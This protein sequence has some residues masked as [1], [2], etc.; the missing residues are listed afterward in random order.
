[1]G[2]QVPKRLYFGREVSM[3][4]NRRVLFDYALPKRAYLGP[5][6]MDT[7]MAFIMCNQ[8]MVGSQHLHLHTD[9]VMRPRLRAAQLAYEKQRGW[10]GPVN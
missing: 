4:N 8:A 1:M 2:A 3:Q 9:K 6:S 7:E 5:T 10:L